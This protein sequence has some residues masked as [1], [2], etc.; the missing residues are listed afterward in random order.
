MESRRIGSGLAWSQVAID[1]LEV[2]REA[3]E[4]EHGPTTP[5]AT[6]A[7]PVPRLD[8]LLTL[9]DDVGIVEHAT[10][11]VPNRAGGYCT[12][13]VARLAVVCSGLLES[14]M[15][16]AAARPELRRMLTRSLAFL[17]HAYD[18]A[19]RHAAQP[20]GLRPALGR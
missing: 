7:W 8:H 15:P 11:A 19:D 16:G 2:L 17:A 4:L 9:V 13:D 3:Y 5:S 18:P 6:G 12:D 10:G 14:A 1:T 20:A